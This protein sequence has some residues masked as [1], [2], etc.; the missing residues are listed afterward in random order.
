M[1]V[2]LTCPRG[3]QWQPD[4]RETPTPSSVCPICG[5]A[6]NESRDLIV[7]TLEFQGQPPEAAD[8]AKTPSTPSPN[9]PGR[10][11]LDFLRR[12][13]E[14]RAFTTLRAGTCRFYRSTSPDTRSSVTLGRGGMGIVYKAR[15]SKLNR[16]VALKM[17][18]AGASADPQQLDRFR[19]RPRRWPACSTPTSCRF[20]R[21]ANTTVA[22]SSHWNMWTVARCRRG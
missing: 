9:A 11:D 16:I 1:A 17:V 19:A 15:Q 7:P 4:G 13:D 22:P 6:A 5:A 3:H 21:S 20:T 8:S 14:F 12:D 2:P 10:A 18:L